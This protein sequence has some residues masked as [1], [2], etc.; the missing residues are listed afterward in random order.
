LERLF[1]ERN[2]PYVIVLEDDLE[3]AVDFFQYFSAMAP[4]L[5]AAR[6]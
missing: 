2:H 6:S 4:L 3:V 1:S 5:D